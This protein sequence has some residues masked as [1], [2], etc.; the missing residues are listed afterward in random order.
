[1]FNVFIKTERIF[2]T[3]KKQHVELT[4]DTMSNKH[5][6]ALLI[7]NAVA[8]EFVYSLYTV[9]RIIYTE[10]V[11]GLGISN[12]Q[13]GLLYSAYALTCTICYFPGGI[14][15]DKVRVKYLGTIGLVGNAVLMFIMA[16]MPSY[17]TFMILFVL[18]GIFAAGFFWGTNFKK[19]RLYSKEG[20]YARNL[21]WHYMANPGA[22]FFAGLLLTSFVAQMGLKQSISCSFILM[23]ILNVI[24]AVAYWFV[25]PF[26]KDEFVRVEKTASGKEKLANIFQAL[27]YPSVWM[28]SIMYFCTYFLYSSAYITS[29]FL[30]SVGASAVLITL[31]GNL[32]S[33]LLP[34]ISAPIGGLIATK[35]KS[36]GKFIL[37]CQIPVIGI[38]LAIL[39]LPWDSSTMVLIL[40]LLL[41]Y[42]GISRSYYS[43]TPSILQDMNLPNNAYGGATGVMSVIGYLP[44]VFTSTL[45]GVWLDNFGT[46]GAFTIIFGTF[47]GMS[48][49]VGIL[50]LLCIKYAK[51][52]KKE[53]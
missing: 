39:L 16:T 27:K 36:T 10:M 30:Q 38:L 5:R 17:S 21:G 22:A 25:C 11:D 40:V 50:A 12:T 7:I 37:Y 2:I 28:V 15:A 13:M 46:K 42:G 29:T 33:N 53:A 1:M 26:F 48:V 43:I 52:T 18:S 31:F 9:Q 44:D 35:M 19:I 41:L 23:G 47:M 32:R 24:C 20:T 8:L 6:Y 34:M 14:L 4:A 3:M 51:T 45:L 49:L